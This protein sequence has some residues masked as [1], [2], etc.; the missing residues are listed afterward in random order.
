MTY[1]YDNFSF[2]YLIDDGLTYLCMTK[3]SFSQRLSFAFLEDIKNKF[4]SAYGS[5]GRTALPMGMQADFCRVIQTRMDFYSSD[6]SADKIIKVQSDIDDVKN[7]MVQNI[8][9]VLE[10]GEKIE[11]LVEKTEAMNDQAMNF[12]KSSTSLKRAMWWK[13]IK[14]WII[15]IIIGI[16]LLYFLISII[17]GGLNWK[18]CVHKDDK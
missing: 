15:V 16:V 13:N 18:K 17:C 5:R 11:L 7:V 6:P 4:H 1:V 2:N 10:R 3:Q 8:E 9:K 12:K 14:L